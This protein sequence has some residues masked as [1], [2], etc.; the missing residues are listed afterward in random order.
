M[1]KAA[2]EEEW[3]PKKGQKFPALE[4][5]ILK[6]CKVSRARR[7]KLTLPH[8]VVDT[9]VFMPVGTQGA[10]KALTMEEVASIGYQ[11]ILSNTYHLGQRPTTKVIDNL[12]GLHEFTQ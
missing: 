8:G 9:P 7:C 11:I 1:V 4:F 6:R 5:E 2:E 10:I 12:G 3:E